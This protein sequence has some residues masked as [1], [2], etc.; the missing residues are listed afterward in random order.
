[1]KQRIAFTFAM[2]LVLSTLMSCWVTYLNLGLVPDF[3]LRWGKAFV[4]AWPAAASIA[5]VFGPRIQRWSQK[6]A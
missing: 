3:L 6:F 1:M 5:F 2:S 4:L